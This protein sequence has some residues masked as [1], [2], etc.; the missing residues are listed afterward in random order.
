M[1][2]VSIANSIIDIIQSSIPAGNTGYVASV[3]IK[4]GELSSIETE[5]LLFAFDIVKAKTPLANARLNIEIIEGKGQCSD[6]GTEFNMNTY[7]TACPKCNSYLIKILQGK[8]M[9][10]VSFDMGNGN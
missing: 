2:E 3:Q 1:H 4:V 6:C 5:A 10:V 7:A 9:K 8:E